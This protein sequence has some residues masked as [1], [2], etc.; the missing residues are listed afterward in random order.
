MPVS[1]RCLCLLA[2]GHP[3]NAFYGPSRLNGSTRRRRPG[4]PRLRAT[5]KERD[6]VRIGKRVARASADRAVLSGT[7]CPSRPDRPDGLEESVAEVEGSAAPP[8]ARQ[9]GPSPKRLPQTPR[10]PPLVSHGF[11]RG[12]LQVIRRTNFVA[13]RR[14]GATAVR[15][16]APPNAPL[17]SLLR[18]L[19]PQSRSGMPPADPRRSAASA[20]GGAD[21]AWRGLE[22]RRHRLKTLPPT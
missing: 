22:S 20:P 8:P 6:L 17:S 18:G 1:Q 14:V 19:P 15:P 21:L 12:L 13:G 2:P 16:P 4:R 3:Q 11:M 10:R 9:S 5:R 7:S